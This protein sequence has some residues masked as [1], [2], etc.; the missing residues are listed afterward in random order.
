MNCSVRITAPSVNL[1]NHRK[2]TIKNPLYQAMAQGVC[3]EVLFQPECI[4]LHADHIIVY[5]LAAADVAD[6]NVVGALCLDVT[7]CAERFSVSGKHGEKD[8]R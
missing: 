5:G 7:A 1:T 3:F 4:L 8:L 2:S 6:L